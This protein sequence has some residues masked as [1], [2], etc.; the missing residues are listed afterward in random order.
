MAL[1]RVRLRPLIA[2]AAFCAAAVALC[3]AGAQ[4]QNASPAASA[5]PPAQQ[6]T[7]M[8]A[9]TP[10]YYYPRMSTP[11]DAPTRSSSAPAS[12]GQRF[13]MLGMRTTLQSVQY[14]ET[15]VKAG[16]DADA[17]PGSNLYLLR[18]CTNPG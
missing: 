11:T 5:A 17:I 2:R 7:V 14:V 15:D 13:E 3:G 12:A 8:C 9:T 6:L 16:I 10:F 18:N 4:A 1:A